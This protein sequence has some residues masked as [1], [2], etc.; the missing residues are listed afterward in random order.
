MILLVIKINILQ[1][2]QLNIEV[3]VDCAFIRM[4]FLARLILK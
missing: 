2:S 1:Q 3:F 4:F